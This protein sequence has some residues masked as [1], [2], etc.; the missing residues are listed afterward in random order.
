MNPSAGSFLNGIAAVSA[1][2]IWAV[3]GGTTG[4]LIAHW[5]GST[6]SVVN[7]PGGSSDRLVGGTALSATDVWAV[8]SGIGPYGYQ[9]LIEHWNGMQWQVVARGPRPGVEVVDSLTSIAASSANDIWAVGTASGATPSSGYGPLTEHWDGSQWS[10]IQFPLTAE[11]YAVALNSIAV[12][13]ESSIWVVGNYE[14]EP[15]EPGPSL[16]LIAHWNGSTWRMVNS[17]S[18]GPFRTELGA[19]VRVPGSGSLWA[20][21]DTLNA[22]F[23][24]QT[25]TEFFC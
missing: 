20:V 18:P 21:G 15:G 17:P 3:G 23:Q 1:Q 2:D 16:S 4:A 7:S 14:M 13:S 11:E 19:V 12:V 9:T 6:W 24:S 10:I 5:N 22:N 8:G 25:L